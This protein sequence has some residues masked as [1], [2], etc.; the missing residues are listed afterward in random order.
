MDKVGFTKDM[1]DKCEIRE[2]VRFAPEGI[3]FEVN[4]AEDQNEAL[5]NMLD[6]SIDA[7]K[8]LGLSKDKT[9]ADYQSMC[10]DG[11]DKEIIIETAMLLDDKDALHCHMSIKQDGTIISQRDMENEPLVY[12]TELSD[13][14]KA[15]VKDTIESKMGKSVDQIWEDKFGPNGWA[16][17]DEAWKKK[18]AEHDMLPTVSATEGRSFDLPPVEN[19]Q[20]ESNKE[21]SL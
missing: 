2:D 5:F 12:H 10:K 20:L 19:E 8:R 3:A 17:S 21:S 6:K 9:F 11:S 16:V 1:F 7:R 13:N 18:M 4:F 15:I 14:E